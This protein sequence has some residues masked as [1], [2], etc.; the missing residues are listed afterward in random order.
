MYVTYH[1]MRW[2]LRWAYAE[3]DFHVLA[4][5]LNRLGLLVDGVHV[6]VCVCMVFLIADLCGHLHFLCL[7]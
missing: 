2:C 7:L 6:L 1:W 4:R 5:F 3:L